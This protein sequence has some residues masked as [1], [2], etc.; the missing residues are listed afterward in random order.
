[1]KRKLVVDDLEMVKRL[2]KRHAEIVKRLQEKTK[3][4]QEK[5][6]NNDK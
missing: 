4:V 6:L 1:M 3:E 5:R 2:E